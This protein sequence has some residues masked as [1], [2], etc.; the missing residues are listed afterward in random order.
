MKY[1]QI[2]LDEMK[3]ALEGWT[4]V[5]GSTATREYV[6][7]KAIPENAG[8]VVRIFISIHKD[9]SVARRCGGDAIR[10][11][12][13]NVPAHKGWISTVR[14]LRVDGWRANLNKAINKVMA[15]S[16]NRWNCNHS[17]H[18]TDPEEINHETDVRRRREMNL[19]AAIHHVK[20]A[21]ILAKA[22]VPAP[23]DC[24][25]WT[26]A[27]DGFVTESSDLNI[28]AERGLPRNQCPH[29]HGFFN[30]KD[31]VKVDRDASGEDIYGWHFKCPTC[32][33]GLL[34]IND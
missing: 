25:A 15:E 9:T 19:K 28:M 4:E 30:K 18:S 2:S 27:N 16:R 10:I 31:I 23:V 5:I 12:A 7:E 32:K 11:C 22:P 14:V 29:C 21:T 1:N 24:V 3:A 33:T 20:Q 26:K 13:V 8:I 17:T 6:Y 34:V